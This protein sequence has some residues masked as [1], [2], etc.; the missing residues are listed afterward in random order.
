MKK[1]ENL[2]RK[3]SKEEQKKIKGGLLD[4][5]G[6]QC[7]TGCNLTCAL[8]CNG[9]PTQGHCVFGQNGKCYCVAVC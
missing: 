3:L 2:G 4:D 5:G 7:G 9:Q 6:G 8:M 1:L